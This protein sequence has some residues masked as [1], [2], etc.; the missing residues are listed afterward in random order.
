MLLTLVQAELQM[1]VLVL[2]RMW[3]LVRVRV[4]MTCL[5]MA[6][7]NCVSAMHP[8]AGSVMRDQVAAG[9]YAAA[10]HSLSD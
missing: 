5:R 2:V 1:W 7:G 8:S 4:L 10:W 6:F 9:S 3:V